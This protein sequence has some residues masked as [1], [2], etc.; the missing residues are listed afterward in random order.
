[1]RNSSQDRD[2]AK[3]REIRFK[4]E[5]VHKKI[6]GLSANEWDVL[7]ATEAEMERAIHEY[8]LLAYQRVRVTAQWA[9][10]QLPHSGLAANYQRARAYRALSEKGD[11]EP[12]DEHS[13]LEDDEDEEEEDAEQAARSQPYGR[14]SSRTR[15]RSTRRRASRRTSSRTSSRTRSYSRSI[16]RTLEE[17]EEE[18]KE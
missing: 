3:L 10:S 12:A 15:S 6:L 5:K 17:D 13:E 18:D 2:E 7:A 4:I 11:E 8:E 16:S 9:R 14:T 1:M